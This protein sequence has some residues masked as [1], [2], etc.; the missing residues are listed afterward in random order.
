MNVGGP[1]SSKFFS[2]QYGNMACSEAGS[3]AVIWS[4]SRFWRRIVVRGRGHILSGSDI[5]KIATGVFA[6]NFYRLPDGA[7]RLVFIARKM[8]ISIRMSL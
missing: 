8:A 2:L 7:D 6:E 3:V 5:F 1:K 4:N